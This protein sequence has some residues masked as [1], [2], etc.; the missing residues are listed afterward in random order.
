[1][2]KRL[3]VFLFLIPVLCLPQILPVPHSTTT[4]DQRTGCLSRL[5]SDNAIV[6][7][8]DPSEDQFNYAI[9]TPYQR[10]YP[11]LLRTA[12]Q[13]NKYV[14]TGLRTD[15]DCGWQAARSVYGFAGFESH[16]HR[17]DILWKYG[18]LRWDSKPK[19]NTESPGWRAVNNDHI[20]PRT[21]KLPDNGTL[22]AISMILERNEPAA[23]VY[24]FCNVLLWMLCG[25]MSFML[26]PFM[27]KLCTDCCT[28]A[29]TADPEEMK[30]SE[31]MELGPIRSPIE[32]L[33][34][35]LDRVGLPSNLSKSAQASGDV[36]SPSRDTLWEPLPLYSVN[37]PSRSASGFEEQLHTPRRE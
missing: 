6:T 1:M 3:Y 21:G 30:D 4:S 36:S 15:E 27:V 28:S 12:L 22:D 26:V 32:F 20:P 33:P 14:I 7:F 8:R 2:T 19:N 34:N 18:D 29:S 17:G 16:N 35:P 23:D 31:G 10:Y 24:E 13:A 5:S 11:D 25:C 9:T 37:E